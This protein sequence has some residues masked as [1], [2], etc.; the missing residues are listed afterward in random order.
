MRQRNQPVKELDLLPVGPAHIGVGNKS[1]SRSTVLVGGTLSR[2]VRAS[3][4][5]RQNIVCVLQPGEEGPADDDTY[6]T[7]WGR[8]KRV[9]G[10]DA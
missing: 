4:R 9:F 1:D 10:C 6:V 2:V 8:A 7:L 3:N 5:H